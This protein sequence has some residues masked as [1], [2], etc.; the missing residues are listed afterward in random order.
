M[1]TAHGKTTCWPHVNYK[2]T[3]TYTH[4]HPHRPGHKQPDA[5]TKPRSRIPTR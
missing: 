1:S 4:T 3:H 2:Q 5:D